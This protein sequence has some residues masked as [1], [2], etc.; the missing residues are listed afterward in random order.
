MLEYLML[1]PED[2]CFFNGSSAKNW[3]FIVVDEAHIFNGAK[4]IEMAMLLRRLKDRVVNGQK[5]RLQCIATSATFGSEK[6]SFPAVKKFAERLFDEDF[7]WIEEDTN[8]QDIIKAEKKSIDKLPSISWTPNSNIYQL[9]QDYIDQDYEDIQWSLLDQR[10]TE[11]GIPKNIIDEAIKIGKQSH[12]FQPFL[13]EILKGDS[14]LIKLRK[15]LETGSVELGNVSNNIFN[16]DL[17]PEQ[18]LISL[19]DLAA[20]ARLSD[21]DQPL[22]PARYHF[23]VRAI[24]GAYISLQPTKKLYLERQEHVVEEGQN[25]L[26]FEVASCRQCGAAYLVGELNEKDGKQYLCQPGKNV[27]ENHEK[28]EY[29]Y[30]P[31]EK[32]IP[33][34][35]DEDDEV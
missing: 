34:P 9:F 13:H 33:V 25:Y 5:G 24:E 1:R 29:F 18:K 21:D 26:V 28:L 15:I 12:A 23:F 22:L 6:K 2:T 16:T 17:D 14:H 27:F 7:D 8:F 3:R 32:Y 19:V 11:S 10:A 20:R 31:F 4:G 30:I 35:I